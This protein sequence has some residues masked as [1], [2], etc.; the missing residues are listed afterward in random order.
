MS[1]LSCKIEIKGRKFGTD[2][3]GYHGNTTRPWNDSIRSIESL[4]GVGM[5]CYATE[6]TK[7]MKT[8]T[9]CSVSSLMWRLATKPVASNSRSERIVK[10]FF[11]APGLP[12]LDAA[13]TLIK[14]QQAGALFWLA[15]KLQK[16]DF[17]EMIRM[18]YHQ[19]AY[20]SFQFD[21]K[22][23]FKTLV[24]YKDAPSEAGNLINV[25][26][27]LEMN[28]RFGPDRSKYKAMKPENRELLKKAS[29]VI[30]SDMVL[31]NTI[32]GLEQAYAVLTTH[33]S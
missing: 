3:R 23:R 28:V 5:S 26:K 31:P 19:E 8:C 10:A 18:A 1:N 9:E 27:A 12:R 33:T 13:K 22:I 14:I 20:D 25:E 6:I 21:R 29:T 17:F 7:H 16:D 15:T 11:D 2:P 32:E 30:N 24:P 4:I